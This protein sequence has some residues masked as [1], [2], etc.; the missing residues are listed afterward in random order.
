MAPLPDELEP[1]IATALN[2]EVVELKPIA[3]PLPAISVTTELVPIAT[4][5]LP[6]A[7]E[8]SPTAILPL[9]VL[10]RYPMEMFLGSEPVAPVPM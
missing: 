6:C 3:T 8:L 2:P 1:P 9:L 7:F 10:A 4:E 5:E